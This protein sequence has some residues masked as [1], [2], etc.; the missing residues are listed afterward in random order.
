MRYR[1]FGRTGL[2]LS[3]VGFGAWGIG[4]TTWIGADD[5]TSIRAL[6]AARDA[7]INFF[8]TALVYGGSHSERLLAQVFGKSE[9][10]VIASK[11]PPK[12]CCGR[13]LQG[14]P[15]RGLPQV[16]RVGK[17]P[18]DSDEPAARDD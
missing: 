9:E 1:K 10:A 5:A 17:P 4:K 16:A 12:N 8:D 13:L 6:V 15:A 11:V 3:E 7:G 2:Q 14:C 18:E